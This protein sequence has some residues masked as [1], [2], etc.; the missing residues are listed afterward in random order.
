MEE[1]VVALFLGRVAVFLYEM[2]PSAFMTP[3]TGMPKESEASLPEVKSTRCARSGGQRPSLGVGLGLVL[4]GVGG[5]DS[6]T[7]SESCEKGRGPVTSVRGRLDI[8]GVAPM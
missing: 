2:E 1:L 5:P 8:S 7:Q 6:K 3:P 4:V